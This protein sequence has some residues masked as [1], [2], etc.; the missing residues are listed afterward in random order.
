MLLVSFASQL[1]GT[2][3]DKLR[4]NIKSGIA[5]T[6]SLHLINCSKDHLMCLNI[7]V[8]DACKD[9]NDNTTGIHITRVH[10]HGDFIDTV[11]M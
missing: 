10:G 7:I 6:S 8:A 5:A 11:V 9:F 4:Q 3:L 1:H 2:M